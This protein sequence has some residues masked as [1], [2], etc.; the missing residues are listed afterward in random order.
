MYRAML[1]GEQLFLDEGTKSLLAVPGITVVGAVSDWR[2]GAELIQE[3]EPD[4]VIVNGEEDGEKIESLPRRLP[5]AIFLLA[6]ERPGAIIMRKARSYGYSGVIRQPFEGREIL[7]TL[8]ELKE[9][10][11]RRLSGGRRADEEDFAEK[12]P[13]KKITSLPTRQEVIVIYS[14]KGGVGKTSLAINLAAAYAK[15][16]LVRSVLLDF[17]VYGNVATALGEHLPPTTTVSWLEAED[18]MDKRAVE[19]RLL[20]HPSGLLFLPAPRNLEDADL[21]D[22]ALATRIIQNTRK[23]FDIVVVDAGP[24]LRDATVVAMDMATKI[25]LMGT[26]DVPTLRSLNDVHDTLEALKIDMSKI[27]V[28]INRIPKKPD[29]SIKEASQHLKYPVMARL[30][31]DPEVQKHTNQGLVLTVNKPD[32]PFA[33][34]VR[35]L[36]GMDTKTYSKEQRGGLFAFFRRRAAL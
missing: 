7:E 36:T 25:Y 33:V 20:R 10:E 8:K 17:D 27:R 5:R 15:T 12:A 24:T 35:K 1:L 28:I 34:E 9:E 32:S 16:G 31:E 29:I 19:K 6:V 22:E 21:L 14:P 2:E 13:P 4:V 23:Y 30:P 11:D 26:L 3:L 18:D